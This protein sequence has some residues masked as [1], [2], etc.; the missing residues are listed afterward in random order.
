[1]QVIAKSSSTSTRIMTHRSLLLRGMSRSFSGTNTQH[2]RSQQQ[3]QHSSKD[4]LDEKS[5][6]QPNNESSR[7]CDDLIPKHRNDKQNQQYT[8][9]HQGCGAST[10]VA[11]GTYWIQS[12]RTAFYGVISIIIVTTFIILTIRYQ[13]HSEADNYHTTI[14]TPDKDLTR[15]PAITELKV[16]KWRQYQQQIKLK[17]SYSSAYGKTLKSHWHSQKQKIRVNSLNTNTFKFHTLLKVSVTRNLKEKS[18]RVKTDDDNDDDSREQDKSDSPSDIP[19]TPPS[20]SPFRTPVPTATIPN[21]FSNKDKDNKTNKPS[22]VPSSSPTAES[23]IV[24]ERNK[25]PVRDDMTTLPT[26]FLPGS[27]DD[28][29]TAQVSPS[30]A[31]HPACSSLGLAGD[32]CPNEYGLSLLCCESDGIDISGMSMFTQILFSC[33]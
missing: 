22:D 31:D 19:S 33:F 4:H 29:D 28:V 32:C 15:D 1:V 5:F 7:I 27:E 30:C 3:Q 16:Q 2:Q 17:G 21:I 26:T 25:N 8:T 20:T 24:S 18:K 9:G 13:P 11:G 23:K 6:T 10:I 14:N 12:L